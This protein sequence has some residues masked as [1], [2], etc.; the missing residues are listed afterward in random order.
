MAASA[1]DF[2]APFGPRRP[3]I[4]PAATENDRPSTATRPP[5]LTLRPSTAR[6]MGA[7]HSPHIRWPPKIKN[8]TCV[9]ESRSGLPPHGGG[10]VK[11]LRLHREALTGMH[12]RSQPPPASAGARAKRR[13]ALR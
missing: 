3:T 13:Q 5:Y 4:S 9:A 6:S 8:G 7:E 1:L 10:S 11:E 12:D 2:P